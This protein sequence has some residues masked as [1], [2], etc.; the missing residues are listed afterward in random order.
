MKTLLFCALIVLASGAYAG[1]MIVSMPV[2][3]SVISIA[4]AGIY[5]RITGSRMSLTGVVGA[6]SLPAYKARIALPTGCIATGIDIIDAEYTIVRGMYNVMP[7]QTQVPF[8]V[9]WDAAP[10]EPDPEIYNSGSFYPENPVEFNGSSVILGIPVAYVKVFPV[11]WNPL[12][13]VVENLTCLTLRVTYESSPDASTVVRRSIQSELRSQ[14]VVRNTV[15]NPDGVSSSGACIVDSKDLTYGE[16]VLISTTDYESYAQELADWKTSK[17][18]PANV[19]TTAWIDANYN[20]Y[21]LQQEIR[22]FLT[23]CRDEGVEYVLIYGDDNRIAG[24]DA[25]ISN[26]SYEEFPPVDLY[27]SDINDMIPGADLWDS[28]NNHI[29]GQ[30]GYDDVDYHPDLWVGRASVNT[31]DECTI[32]NEKVYSYERVSSTDYFESSEIEERIGYTTE[33][34]WPGCYGSAG[35]ELIS[36]F[37]P[38]A[39]EEEKCYD[40][41]GQNSVAITDSM[42]NAGPHHVYHS[43]HGSQTL[44]SLPGGA[45]TTSHFKNLKNIS[46]GGLPAIWNSISCLIGAL[47]YGVDCMGDAWNNSPEG[48]GFGAFNARFGWGN[49]GNPG[50]GVSEILS[51]YFYDVMWNDDLYILGVAHAMGDDEMSPPGNQTEDWCVKEYNLFGDPELPMWFCIASDLDVSHTA[52]ITGATNVTV[53]V[54]SGGSP[55]SEARICLQKGDWQSGDIYLVETT[56]SSGECTFYINPESTGTIS[57]VAWARDHISYQGTIS[58]TGTGFEGGAPE[59]YINCV[60][61]VYPSPALNS[62]AIPFCIASNGFARVDIYDLTG[63]LVKNLAAEEMIAGEHRLLWRLEDTNGHAVPSGVYHVRV[64]TDSWTDTVNM[65]VVR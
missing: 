40:S 60:D 23:D 30:Y 54:T 56:N 51:R 29:W 1:E 41:E 52:T 10:V 46:N 34:L 45:Y 18:V 22:A 5:T 21:D 9:E 6:P 32:F 20:C 3:D 4:E 65:V 33:M 15:V 49:P 17:G 37:V 48:G 55:V 25:R 50:Y 14:E 26:G 38:S 19:Y 57:V 13:R 16:Y 58:V 28:N 36:P 42:L 53:A 2:D 47:D 11:R 12:S 43:S 59:A 64:S 8:S 61:A 24:R 35:A 27:W 44:F 7:T 39:W 31:T 63:R 62:A